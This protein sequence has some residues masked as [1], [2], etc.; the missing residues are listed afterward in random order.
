MT[1]LTILIIIAIAIALLA[2]VINRGIRAHRKQIAAGWEDLIGKTAVVEI[3]LEPKGIVLIEGERWTAIIDKGQAEAGE[4]VIINKVEG[5]KL[6][7]T[8]KEQGGNQ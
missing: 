2:L 7:V 8:K 4:E 1:P 6:R 3:A 5:L